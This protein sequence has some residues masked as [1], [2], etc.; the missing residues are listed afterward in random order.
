MK[1]R[2]FAAVFAMLIVASFAYI[3]EAKGGG[4]LA[5]ADLTDCSGSASCGGKGSPSGCVIK[6]VDGAEITC[7]TV[8]QE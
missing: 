1:K 7:P 5:C 8:R 2:F 4:N 3:P 6:C